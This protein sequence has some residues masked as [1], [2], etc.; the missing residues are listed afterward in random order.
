MFLVSPLW[1][2]KAQLVMFVPQKSIPS[3]VVYYYCAWYNFLRNRQ[4]ND[5]L[6]SRSLNWP[7]KIQTN[8]FVA[9][10]W[11][12]RGSW[13]P[14]STINKINNNL[15]DG[16]YHQ[17]AFWSDLAN[18]ED[19]ACTVQMLLFLPILSSCSEISRNHNILGYTHIRGVHL[20]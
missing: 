1:D 7:L 12:S 15:I 14:I 20:T 19:S 8:K 16:K 17:M 4:K 11:L 5:N 13:I 2:S 9:P 18:L 6:I 3:A 10:F